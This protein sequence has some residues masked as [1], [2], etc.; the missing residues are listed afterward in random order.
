MPICIFIFTKSS[1]QCRANSVWREHRRLQDGG[2]ALSQPVN[3][4]PPTF[5]CRIL[6]LVFSPHTTVLVPQTGPLHSHL[7]PLVNVA[8][9]LSISSNS[10]RVWLGRTTPE[11]RTSDPMHADSMGPDSGGREAAWQRNLLWPS[12]QTLACART[13]WMALMGYE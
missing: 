13:T 9:F 2:M 5:L 8:A 1:I 3:P 11:P 4:L 7:E 10:A 6:T 12:V